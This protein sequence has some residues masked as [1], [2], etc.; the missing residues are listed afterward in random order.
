MGALFWFSRTFDEV[1]R[2]PAWNDREF[3][4]KRRPVCRVAAPH[5]R[6]CGRTHVWLLRDVPG[7][8]ALEV[9]PS[10][11]QSLIAF[12]DIPLKSAIIDAL[13][14]L[15]QGPKPGI[16]SAVVVLSGIADEEDL[17]NRKLDQIRTETDLPIQGRYLGIEPEPVVDADGVQ[18]LKVADVFPGSAAEK[19]GLH[20]G[21]VIHSINGYLTAKRDDLAWIMANA[22]PDG[23]VKMSVRTASD[24]KVHTITAQLAVEPGKTS[25]PSSLPPVSNGPPPASR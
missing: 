6:K 20:A 1:G 15:K 3:P 11:T 10:R 25:R 19:A 24:G 9:I 18:G 16:N 14:E 21:D 8:Q 2:F 5:H 12:P 17:L 4:G 13:N 22:A 7:S 23:V